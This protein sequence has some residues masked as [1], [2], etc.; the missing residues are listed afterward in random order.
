MSVI[1]VS[2]LFSIRI[3]RNC[4]AIFFGLFFG[5]WGGV[6]RTNERDLKMLVV[7][8]HYCCFD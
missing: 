8:Q 5:G 6:I 7:Y 2:F 1:G 4:W 3:L